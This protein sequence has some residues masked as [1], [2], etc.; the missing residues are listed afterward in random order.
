MRNPR[1]KPGA[2]GRQSAS[3]GDDVDE[4]TPAAP[5]DQ[6]SRRG[7]VEVCGGRFAIIPAARG[8]L[9]ELSDGAHRFYAELCGRIGKTS[10]EAEICLRKYATVL[11]VHR[12]TVQRRR[13][14]LE[15]FGCIEQV[16][17]D[18]NSKQT[19]IVHRDPADRAAARLRN[20]AVIDRRRERKRTHRSRQRSFDFD[21]TL[22]SHPRCDTDVAHKQ[23]ILQDPLSSPI[24]EPASGEAEEQQAA[25]QSDGAGGEAIAPEV[26]PAQAAQV[27]WQPI[28]AD[29]ELLARHFDCTLQQMWVEL[30]N[31]D[32]V[33]LGDLQRLCWRLRAA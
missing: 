1:P 23:E 27:A 5:P 18:D 15:R 9:D 25:R 22:M 26:T 21:A 28:N 4:A 8:D 20:E 3:L 17:G 10:G 2:R 16:G 29:A 30:M 7:L 24:H 6:A 19:F 12:R 13:L 32:P 11:G 33:L 14:E 31:A